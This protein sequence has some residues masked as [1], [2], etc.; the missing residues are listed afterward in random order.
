[1]ANKYS[2]LKSKTFADGK[3]FIFVENWHCPQCFPKRTGQQI[4]YSISKDNVEF[5]FRWDRY[6]YTVRLVVPLDG[7]MKDVQ[8]DMRPM[9]KYLLGFLKHNNL[10]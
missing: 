10:I 5:D 1:M 9:A 3:P 2:A 8:E 6:L 4:C 7:D